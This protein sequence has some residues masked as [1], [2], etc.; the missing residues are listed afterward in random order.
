MRLG[1]Y[2]S[3]GS[4]AAD[5]GQ[6]EPTAGPSGRATNAPVP[7]YSSHTTVMRSI[8]HFW[9]RQISL[10]VPF[11]ACRDNL[12][13]MSRFHINRCRIPCNPC[14]VPVRY[15]LSKQYVFLTSYPSP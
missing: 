6:P 1:S 2:H 14:A 3:S 8:K 5:A 15:S 11:E 13:N 12:G 9:R 4:N 7:R 10:T